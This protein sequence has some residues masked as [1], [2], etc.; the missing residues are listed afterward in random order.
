MGDSGFYFFGVGGHSRSPR[1]YKPNVWVIGE[2]G[3]LVVVLIDLFLSGFSVFWHLDRFSYRKCFL[4]FV[5]GG[6]N[7]NAVSR[8]YDVQPLL[9]LGEGA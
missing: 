6:V 1:C 3:F 2:L 7:V 4:P 9:D 8:T 5:S